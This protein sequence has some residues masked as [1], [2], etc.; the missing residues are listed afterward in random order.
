MRTQTL[1][2]LVLKQ[3]SLGNHG[4]HIIAAALRENRSVES[5]N[6]GAVQMSDEGIKTLAST[7]KV[8]SR[9]KIVD[10]S[11]NQV[12][13]TGMQALAEMVVVNRSL[14]ELWL[15]D[16][17]TSLLGVQR[18]SAEMQRNSTLHKFAFTVKEEQGRTEA[19]RKTLEVVKKNH[20]VRKAMM[21]VVNGEPVLHLKRVTLHA[22]GVDR[23][24]E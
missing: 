14:K 2:R 13:D 6:L 11:G 12:G 24:A 22:G 18:F 9:L 4:A 5:I 3:N 16:C 23:L 1:K 20:S 15:L 19:E 8:N 10:F 17:C 7:L 21:E